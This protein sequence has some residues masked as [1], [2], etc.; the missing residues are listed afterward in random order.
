MLSTTDSIALSLFPSSSWKDCPVCDY[1]RGA[2]SRI[3]VT[4]SYLDSS[5]GVSNKVA[6]FR[7]AAVSS[8]STPAPFP[9]VAVAV[10]TVVSVL[11]LGGIIALTVFLVRR[12]RMKQDSSYVAM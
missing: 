10:G 2:G 1:K 6:G 9:V 5:S 3:A 4:A 8:S 7:L 12:N 11:V